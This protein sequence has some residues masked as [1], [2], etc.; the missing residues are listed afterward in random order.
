MTLGDVLL[1][2]LLLALPASKAIEAD[3]LVDASVC[4]VKHRRDC[5]SARLGT[6]SKAAA[7][8]ISHAK[9]EGVR[10]E[11]VQLWPP[12]ITGAVQH[13]NSVITYYANGLLHE[14]TWR[15]GLARE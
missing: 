1:V 15:T 7:E 3:R 6:S 2:E 10:V 5:L 8:C 12:M 14:H 9:A 11:E 13:L 4:F